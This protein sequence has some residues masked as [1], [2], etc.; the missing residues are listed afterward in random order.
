[1]YLDISGLIAEG[2]LQNIERKSMTNVNKILEAMSRLEQ[3]VTM[4]QLLD[5]TDLKPGVMSG[6]LFSLCKS[7]RLSREKMEVESKI[8]PKMKWVYKIVANS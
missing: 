1:M 6:T 2:L 8:G 3:P 5:A 7:G 4:K